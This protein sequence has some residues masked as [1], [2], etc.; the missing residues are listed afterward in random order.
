[1]KKLNVISIIKSNWDDSI[2]FRY[3]QA[4]GYDYEL[5]IKLLIHHLNGV[6]KRFH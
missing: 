1:M 3:L 6:I 4:T 2:S 5:A